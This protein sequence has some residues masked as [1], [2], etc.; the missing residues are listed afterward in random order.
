V[1]AVDATA[2][3]AG[4]WFGP[5]ASVLEELAERLPPESHPE[6]AF[7]GDRRTHPLGAVLRGLSSTSPAASGPPV[8]V[9]G[10][11][12]RFPVIGPLL[13]ELS[14]D[15]ARPLLVLGNSP[16][17]DAEDW[18]VPEFT[19]RTLVY[20]LTGTDAVSHTAFREVG[21]ETELSVLVE[22]LRDP[23]LGVR[24]GHPAALP[25][26][27]DNDSYRWDDGALVWEPP[28]TPELTA[29]FLHPEGEP[30]HA[31]VTKGHGVEHRLALTPASPS[32]A[33]AP[34]PLRPA[35]GNVLNLW[36]RGT[37]YWCGGCSRSHPPGQLWCSGS[38]GGAALFPTLR[39]CP[40]AAAYVAEPRAG[41]WVLT[42]IRRGVLP[43]PDG[44]VLVAR[45]GAA[46]EYNFDAGRWEPFAEEPGA[47]VALDSGGYL[48]R[49]NPRG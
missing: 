39:D 1:V 8:D 38:T 12:G 47:F 26:D 5:V 9:A 36:R 31:M 13:W 40:A 22:H 24:V 35:E 23:V 32:A 46:A 25:V 49:T 20:R 7:L 30:P 15:P 34:I 19:G 28:A 27:W 45:S 33:P 48:I 16:L 18:A 4:L 44:R 3:A 21:P 17:I 10:H 41:E 43:L 14:R 6:V 2:A 37:P 42:P 29:G 11:L